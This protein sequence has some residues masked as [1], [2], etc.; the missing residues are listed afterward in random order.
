MYLE[1]FLN[2]PSRFLLRWSVEMKLVVV[3]LIT[4]DGR[5]LGARF[6]MLTNCLS[7]QP[8]VRAVGVLVLCLSACLSL[9]SMVEGTKALEELRSDDCPSCWKTGGNLICMYF[10][11]ENKTEF[12]VRPRCFVCNMM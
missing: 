3:V 6:R 11:L 7:F 9:F 4:I 5:W 2:T 12:E 8:P 10:L 1:L